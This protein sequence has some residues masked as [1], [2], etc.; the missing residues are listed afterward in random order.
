MSGEV[1]GHRVTVLEVE[2]QELI[3]DVKELIVQ[4]REFFKAD[5]VCECSR[6]KT[7]RALE[8]IRGIWWVLGITIPSTLGI[9][10]K[11]AFFK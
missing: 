8:Q 10:V 11:L 3:K 6:R 2:V 9:L 4:Q 1:N 5:G 7:D